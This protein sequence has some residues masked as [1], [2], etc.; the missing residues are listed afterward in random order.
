M[1]WVLSLP[2]PPPPAASAARIDCVVQ[3]LKQQLKKQ[4]LDVYDWGLRRHSF[5]SRLRS[6]YTLQRGAGQSLPSK[7][8]RRLSIYTTR[9]SSTLD[10]CWQP[11]KTSCTALA[12][13]SV[14]ASASVTALHG[15]ICQFVI[16]DVTVTGK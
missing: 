10:F 16:D 13:W 9:F 6:D 3:Q 4:Q 11:V 12:S 7:D 5:S 2:Q 1:K 14:D 8:R 15:N